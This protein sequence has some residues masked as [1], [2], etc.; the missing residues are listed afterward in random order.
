MEATLIFPHQLFPDHPAIARN[1]KVFVLQD[2]LFIND[3]IYKSKFHKSKILMHLLSTK[4]YHRSLLKKKYDTELISVSDIKSN[5]YLNDF[6]K[7]YN[8][9]KVHFCNVVDFILN[10]RIIKACKDKSI[11]VCMYDSPG[12][13]L[14][15]NTVEKE[16]LNKKSHFMASFY[17]KQRQR[18]N[19]LVNHDGSPTGGKWSFDHENR[20]RFP[21]NMAPPEELK[22][23][24][25]NNDIVSSKSYIE[26]HYSKNPG[27]FDNFNFPINREQA[28]K[29]FHFFLEQKLVNFGSYEDAI[30]KNELFL[31]HGVITPYLN[32]G[33][34]TPREIITDT[35]DFANQNS[36]PIN[37][38]EGF[39]RQIIGW[40]EFMRGIYAVDGVKQRNSNFWN[41]KRDIPNSFY[42]ATTGIEPLDNTIKKC[43]DNAYV[44]HIERLMV[45]GNLM[46]LLEI[47]P[48]SVY[49]WFMELFI[50][51]YDWVMVPNVY[52]MS[53]F[54]DGGLLATKPYISGS[55]YILKM[56]D[57]KRGD[58]CKIWDAL[59]WKFINK[60][61]LFFKK[62]PRMNMMVSM[63]DKKGEDVKSMLN[64]TVE[65]YCSHLFP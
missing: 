13:Y 26:K 50:D 28:L 16:F 36:V 62:N 23:T 42:T 7:K 40:R 19:I 35:L 39:I 65:E 63:Y 49:K 55:N 53:Q 47:S 60:N 51:S 32:I 10:K 41:Y 2:P 56:S 46:L 5:N 33:L 4:A 61:R 11:K 48:H 59:Y 29:S 44:H 27:S 43:L 20:K 30:V 38:L 58:W 14:S 12:F 34:I 52:G 57:Y 64:K 45:L 54:S 24:Y 18:Y 3:F 15:S 25:N 31:F 1:R 9:S 21:K 6:F 37:S 22:I 17:K 8:I